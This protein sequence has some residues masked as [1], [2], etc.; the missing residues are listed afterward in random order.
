M[1]G[2]DADPGHPD[3]EGALDLLRSIHL[4]DEELS[5]KDAGAEESRIDLK[6]H[7]SPPEG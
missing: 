1:Y 2:R 3:A 4:V 6:P 5:G 7:P